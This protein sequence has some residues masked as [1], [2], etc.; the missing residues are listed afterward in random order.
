MLHFPKDN[1][2]YAKVIGIFAQVIGHLAEGIGIF[3]QVTGHFAEGTG[4]FA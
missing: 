3:A 4:F 1:F 2:N